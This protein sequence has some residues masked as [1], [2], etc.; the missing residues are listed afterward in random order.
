MPIAFSLVFTDRLFDF[1]KGLSRGMA[2]GVDGFAAFAAQKLVD[3]Q[4]RAF[5]EDVPQRHIDPR[6]R[7]SQH[8]PVSPVRADEGRLP[9][10]FDARGVFPDEKGLQ[11]LVDGCLDGAG[12]LREGRAAQTVK[13]RFI[14]QHFDDHQADI[15][16]GRE[17]RLD[18]GD[19]QRRRPSGGSLGDRRGLLVGAEG[20]SREPGQPDCTGTQ[21]GR[22]QPVAAMHRVCSLPEMVRISET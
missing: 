17:N 9:D 6:E 19:S 1:L 16:R 3:R 18:V 14:R 2:V 20:E 22:F 8:R 7:V 13:S 12:P 11:E 4:F 10:V 5:A 21:Q 15:R